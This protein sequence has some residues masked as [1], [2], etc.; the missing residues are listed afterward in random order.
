[1][2]LLFTGDDVLMYFCFVVVIIS[3]ISLFMGL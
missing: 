3:V 1:M 2:A